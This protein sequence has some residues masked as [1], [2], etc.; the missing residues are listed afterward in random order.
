MPWAYDT[1]CSRLCLPFIFCV[2]LEYSLTEASEGGAVMQII[3][4]IT[5]SKNNSFETQNHKR[6]MLAVSSGVA[7]ITLTFV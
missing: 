1:P 4:I 6:K 5:S 7:R 2:Q 3:I